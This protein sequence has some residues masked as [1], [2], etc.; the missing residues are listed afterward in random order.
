MK[1]FVNAVLRRIAGQSGNIV[2]PDRNQPGKYL[3]V[4]YSYPEWLCNKYLEEYGMDFTEEM[5]SYKKEEAYTCVRFNPL[6]CSRE[7]FE[8]KLDGYGYEYRRG[9]Y[10]EDAYYVK[11]I[12]D[13]EHWK[14]YTKGELTVQSEAS[15][16]C[17]LAARIR[18]G[19][20]ILDVCA[21]PGG[22]S[23]YAAVFAPGKQTARDIHPHRVEMMVKNFQRLGAEKVK[24]EVFDATLLDPES[25]VRYDRVLVDAPCS[26]LGLLYRKPDIKFSKTPDGIEELIRIQ[27]QILD[28]SAQY[29]APGGRIVYSTCTINRAEN[30]E[31]VAAFLETHKDFIL[32]DLAKE[33]SGSLMY[34]VKDGMLQL[35]PHLDGT[36]GFFI[37]AME[38]KI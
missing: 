28:T 20:A 26:A 17:V 19:Q 2:Y 12:R 5:L 11:N 31:I 38:R 25:V 8:R 30:Q 6:R 35:F 27:R 15:M 34:R 9:K 18:K 4:L 24:T 1:G 32:C 21:A 29:V 7:E 16:L 36:D 10:V 22:K 14:L 3:S 37:A 23:A 33:F 13:I